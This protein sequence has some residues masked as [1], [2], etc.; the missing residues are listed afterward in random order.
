MRAWAGYARV[1]IAA[2]VCGNV[3][4]WLPLE[5]AR[6]QA[7]EDPHRESRRTDSESG[8]ARRIEP[9]AVG[10]GIEASDWTLWIGAGAV[11][12]VLVLSTVILR[13]RNHRVG[14]PEVGSRTPSEVRDPALRIPPA[15]GRD[16]GSA[17]VE[18]PP[19]GPAFVERPRPAAGTA[20]ILLV[21][22]EPAV[23]S[24]SANMLRRLGHEVLL[25]SDGEEA[26]RIF[27]EQHARLDLVILDVVMPRIGGVETLHT[28]AGIDSAVPVVASSG[29]AESAE[30]DAMLQ[31]GARG[32]LCKPFSLGELA[33]IVARLVG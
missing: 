17:R 29:F 22:D 25:A 16:P 11:A 7:S 4:A 15:P 33:E 23:R 26:A 10:A 20:R 30:V 8:V 21:D 6:A 32:V 19:P 18:P 9:P 3:L 14:R 1:V 2:F 12:A 24:A 27:R 13:P 31:Q 5:A 28:L